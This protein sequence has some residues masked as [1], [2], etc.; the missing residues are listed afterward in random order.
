MKHLVKIAGLCLASMLVLGMAITATASA[1]PHWLV[2]LKENSGTTTTKWNSNQCSTAAAGGGWEWSP[3]QAGTSLTIEIKG[4]LKLKDTK[5]L[6]GESEVECVGKALGFIFP[7]PTNGTVTKVE[8]TE[9]RGVKVC[10]KEGATAE[11]I[12]LP[13]ETEFHETEK[14][15]LLHLLGKGAGKE[16]GWKVKCKAG[17]GG[18]QTDTCETEVGKGELLLL[19]NRRTNTE[20]LVLATYERVGKAKCEKGGEGSGVVEGSVGILLESGAGLSVS[21]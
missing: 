15:I 16:P 8:V 5:T 2:C 4:T 12:N 11:A 13:W 3:V 1:A 9:C 20:L 10:E 6:L 17:I 21:L 7:S 18:E 19:E 14:K